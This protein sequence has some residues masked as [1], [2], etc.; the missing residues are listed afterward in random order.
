MS[1]SPRND[2]ASESSPARANRLA[3]ETSPYLLQH[4]GNP[5]DWHPWG[6]EAIRRARGENKPIFLSIGYSACHWCHVMERESFEDA[7]IAAILNE[8]FIS[9]KVDREER[10]EVDEIYMT[11]VQM[12]TGQGGWP[13]SVFLTPELKP[14]FG[15]TYFPPE[16][17]LGMP[18]FGKVLLAI[19]QAW[20]D[21]RDDLDD[22]ADRVLAALREQASAAA[23][24]SG[25]LDGAIFARA[26]TALRREFDPQWGGFG[27]PPKFPPGAAIAFLL[28]EQL[29]TGDR[30]LLAMAAITLDRMAAGGMHDQIGGGFHRY[31]VDA[32]W[33]VPHF[34]KMLYDNAILAKVY[35]EAWQASGHQRHRRV[36]EGIFEYVLRDMTDATGGFHSAEDA[37]SEGV[38]GKFYVWTR[39]EILAALGEEDGELFCDFYGAS[40]GGNFEGKNILHVARDPA[41]FAGSRGLSPQELEERLG[42]LRQKLFEVRSRRARPGKDDKVL[43]AWNGMMISALARGYQAFGNPR[44]REAAERAADFVLAEMVRD[45]T[46]LRTY[47]GGREGEGQSKLPAYLD[48]Y[49]E[50]AFALVDLYEATF[51][52]G[53]LEA[54]DR[55]VGKMAADFWDSE[56]GGFF[57]T[58]GDHKDLLVRMKP[59]YD[60]AVPSG[61]SVAAVVLLRL[62]RLLDQREYRDKAE[63]ILASMQPQ[64]ATQPRGH[65]N[66]ICAADFHL[67]PGREIA[68]VGQPQGSDTERLLRVVHGRFIPNKVLALLDPGSPDAEAAGRRVPLLAGKTMIDGK[69]TAYVCEN[70]ACKQPVD[71]AAALEAMLE[72]ISR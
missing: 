43:A 65:L 68:L 8:H 72:E 13:L 30:D 31:S 29:E 4:A 57:Y 62:A 27:G 64:I 12:M 6:N 33:L 56:H 10:P 59:S 71:D 3:G 37:D 21:R 63:Q 53:R 44:Y 22:N 35:I 36:A 69:A 60:G 70:F 42:P 15:G 28:R 5:V 32:K 50:M 1:D 54:A 48:D 46:L 34:E 49:A 39:R 24:A 61:N 51:D 14:F 58:S 47:R 41:A 52:L 67:R 18:S 20:R 7:K 38:E 55:L 11:A 26:A 66:L 2:A 17:R 45:G 9:I 19:S 16:D 23:P 25:P 40:E